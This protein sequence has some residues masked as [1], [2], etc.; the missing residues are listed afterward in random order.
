M[1]RRRA[2]EVFGVVDGHGGAGA[3]R[4]VAEILPSR[5]LEVQAVTSCGASGAT[6]QHVVSFEVGL[7][8]FDGVLGSAQ[9]FEKD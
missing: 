5:M 7:R 6:A 3:A 8:L 1:H 2:L 9:A 4:A